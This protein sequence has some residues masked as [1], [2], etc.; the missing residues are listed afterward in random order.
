MLYKLFFI[1][2]CLVALQS[3]MSAQKLI[4]SEANPGANNDSLLI[5]SLS[6]P[7]INP[8]AEPIPTPEQQGYVKY[9]LNGETIYRKDLNGIIIEY[10]PKNK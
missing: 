1:V 2:I 3:K 8:M 7:K 5:Y 10:Q 4:P 9:I 6:V